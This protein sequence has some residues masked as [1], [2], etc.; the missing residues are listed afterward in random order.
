MACWCSPGCN[1]APCAP[2]APASSLSAFDQLP[3][4]LLPMSA[5]GDALFANRAALALL[6]GTDTLTL[7]RATSRHGLGRLTTRLPHVN[8]QIARA[9]STARR[10][11][12]ATHFSSAIK[13]P[14]RL[15]GNDLL[16]QI[17]RLWPASSFDA[18]GQLPEVIAF[19]TDTDRPLTVAPE[20]LCSL[21]GLT[22]AEAKA[23]VAAT[24]AGSVAELAEALSL[25]INTVKTQLK[26]V[27]KNGR[28]R[29]SRTDA[30]ADGSGVGVSWRTATRPDK[31][32]APSGR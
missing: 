3:T 20:S 23:A 29:S 31:P 4:A 10:I 32:R 30:I 25:G 26:Q 11:D 12:D 22:L 27:C 9:L 18:D 15:P 6:A 19:L 28:Q 7:D 1:G 24:A 17:S 2:K 13:V 21:G 8:R 16:L 14:G 5:A